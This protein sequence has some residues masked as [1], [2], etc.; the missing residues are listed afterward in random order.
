MFVLHAISAMIAAS[1][2]IAQLS[3]LDFLSETYLT[4]SCW[5]TVC[6]LVHV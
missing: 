6:P 1:L 5:S 3:L 2:S 4:I